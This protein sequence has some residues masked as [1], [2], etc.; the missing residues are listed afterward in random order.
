MGKYLRMYEV[1]VS[2][3][4]SKSDPN[5]VV[6][7][8]IVIHFFNHH[9]FHIITCVLL[10]KQRLHSFQVVIEQKSA[11]LNYRQACDTC[12]V[13]MD[14]N[15]YGALNNE[16]EG[17]KRQRFDILEPSYE[18]RP[19]SQC[20]SH[21]N[22]DGFKIIV[23]SMFVFAVAVTVALIITIASGN[24][25]SDIHLKIVRNSFLCTIYYTWILTDRLI[26]SVTQIWIFAPKM[27][28]IRHGKY[29]Q[30]ISVTIVFK[31]QRNSLHFLKDLS[32]FS[33]FFAINYLIGRISGT[34]FK[35]D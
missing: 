6:N 14:N 19:S 32:S 13:N 8:C 17:G 24:K 21:S 35:T 15:N 25:N 30:R 34:K 1:R 18:R 23:I 5:R 3:N 2:A 9:Y 7:F 29:F 20:C 31:S 12:T 4:K 28:Q 33:S 16:Q 26:I 27:E 11:A 22:T 10:S